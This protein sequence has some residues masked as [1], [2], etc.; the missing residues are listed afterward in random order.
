VGNKNAV[1]IDG[2]PPFTEEDLYFVRK[3]ISHV[4][5]DSTDIIN[6]SGW[7]EACRSA[8]ERVDSLNRHYFSSAFKT[9]SMQQEP[10]YS[11]L[12]DDTEF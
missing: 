11:M 12:D 3:L 4:V 6:E 10:I 2:F 5:P 8:I 7:T 1:K 9:R